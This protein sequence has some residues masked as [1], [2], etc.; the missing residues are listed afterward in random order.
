MRQGWQLNS[1]GIRSHK[2]LH[3]WQPGADQT[4]EIRK[5]YG[6]H[7]YPTVGAPPTKP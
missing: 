5:H 1:T 6:A 7:I 3:Y 2:R 4:A